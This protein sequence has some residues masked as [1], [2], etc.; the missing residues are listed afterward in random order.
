[1][2]SIAD[3]MLTIY[4]FVADFLD[5]HPTLANW[6]H[7]NNNVPEFTDAEVITI[8]LLQ[9][10]LGVA[11]LKQTYRLV[12]NNWQDAFPKLPSYA[13]WLARLHQL[14]FLMAH[15]WWEALR[16]HKMPGCLYLIDSKPIPV[17][18]PIRHGRV[19][20]MRLEG[21]YFGKS[22]TGW[23]FGFKLHLLVHHSGVVLA[24]LLTAGN[25][26][27]KDA[28]VL[29]EML[30]WAGGGAVL[31]D[32][33]Y[34]DKDLLAFLE[35]EYGVVVVNPTQA[36]EKRAL[37]SSLRERIETTL[38]SLWHRFVDRVFSR[39]FPGLWNTIQLK[40]LHFNLCRTGAIVC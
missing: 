37:I 33:G 12:K 6:R 3:Q 22:S 19:R 13:R 9:G 17:C 10:C 8:G 39:S 16:Q 32:R 14:S 25:C 38:S 2:N 7:S 27:D 20:L 30:I 29:Q 1:M 40:I 4:V 28:D 34:R 24:A 5:T 21:A 31:S 26:C 35:T 11:S 15:L 18:K 36:G 23:F